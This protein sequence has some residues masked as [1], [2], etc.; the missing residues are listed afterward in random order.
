MLDA[1]A[2]L[3]PNALLTLLELG[4]RSR[5]AGSAA[6]LG[7]L[8]ANDTHALLPYRQ[9][10][11]WTQAAGI[12]TL[13]GVLKVEANA[14]YVQWL[15][16]VFAH[17][18][19]TL[20]EPAR[21][22][23]AQ[24]PDDLAQQWAEWLPAE[25]CWL[26]LREGKESRTSVGVIFAREEPFSPGALALLAEWA[27][28][29]LVAWKAKQS[30]PSLSLAAVKQRLG[31]LVR[32]QGDMDL[33]WW[34]T[35][36]ARLVLAVALVLLLPVRLTV[37]APAE[38]VPVNPSL[39]RA[40]V[41][42]VIESFAVRP[43]QKVRAGQPLFAF[44]VAL[45][46][47]RLDVARQEV[48]TAQAELRQASQAALSDPAAR[49]Q[50]SALA[51]RLEERQAQA[52]YIAQQMERT[53]VVAPVDGVVLLDEPSEWIGR[54]VTT[55]QTVLRIAALDKVE[56][57]AW[58]GVADAIP[59]PRDAPLTLYLN[60]SPLSPVDAT[61]RYMAFEPMER[62]G[63]DY[64]YRLRA[65]PDGKVDHRVGLKG[66]ARVGGRRVPL[67]Y[68]IMRRPLATLRVWLGW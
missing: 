35:R 17:C 44:D 45:V 57:E 66:T 20:K 56:V 61:V 2:S 37:L 13:S 29:W 18:H 24:L 26:P 3:A 27:D 58:L 60:A 67:G 41:D 46:R 23:A 31:A 53:T 8:L 54:P 14:P 15:E 9:A 33:P 7:F 42:G 12:H 10:A 5:H 40:P 4:R 52:A 48:L 43:N 11:V 30:R 68:W 64:A 65:V 59:L 32:P 50:L 36:L 63:G 51:G 55:G 28:T 25:A 16:S 49:L 34:K 39:V 62:P 22:G 38:L 6:E 19:E 47:S 21:I 1:E